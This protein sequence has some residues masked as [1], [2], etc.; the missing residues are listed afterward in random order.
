MLVF[1]SEVCAFGVQHIRKT[2]GPCSPQQ[3]L[4]TLSQLGSFGVSPF[5][6]SA[7]SSRVC[8]VHAFVL[9]ITCLPQ[10]ELSIELLPPSRHL[11]IRFPSPTLPADVECAFGWVVPVPCTSL[12]LGPWFPV[13]SLFIPLFFLRGG[14]P[15]ALFL[16]GEWQIHRFSACACWAA[17]RSVLSLR[18]SRRC[19]PSGLHGGERLA[20]SQAPSHLG[21]GSRPLPHSPRPAASLGLCRAQV[22]CRPWAGCAGH[23]HFSCRGPASPE[24]PALPFSDFG[25]LHFISKVFS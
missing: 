19:L 11:H 22:C 23:S 8:L 13:F 4:S 14:V 17:C 18:A 16:G 2:A 10:N 21:P 6:P 5:S 24:L 20:S 7:R 15:S 25:G 3:L 9:G 1:V 12:A